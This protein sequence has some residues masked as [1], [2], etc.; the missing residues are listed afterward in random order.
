MISVGDKVFIEMMNFSG[1]TVIAVQ[2]G[3][4]LCQYFGFDGPLHGW[5]NLSGV[6]KE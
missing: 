3:R 5:F 6:S 4:V 1:A 2:D